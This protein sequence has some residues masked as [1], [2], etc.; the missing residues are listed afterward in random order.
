METGN[1]ELTILMP[2]LNE[3]NSLK[4]CIDKGKK[5]L[6]EN[7]I[8]GEVLVTDNGSTDGSQQIAVENGARVA[9]VAVKGYGSALMGGIRAARGKYVIMGDA[10]DS[11]NFSNLAP[12]VEKLRQGYDLVMGNRFRGGIEEGAMPFL[13]KY[14]GNPVLSKIGRIFFD[15]KIGDFH[16]G[17]RGFNRE[18]IS[19]LDLNTTGMEFASE[20]VIKSSL[21]QLKM[22]EVPTTLSRDKRDRPP[23]LRTWRDGWR[24]LRFMLLY[25]PNWLFL[26]PGMAM[27]VLGLLAAVLIFQ[28]P[29]TIGRITFDIHT[30]L[31]ASL[32]IMI[33]Y[34]SV[35][36][37]LLGKVFAVTEGFLPANSRFL[38]LFK[39]FNLEK[40]LLSGMILLL[41]GFGFLA[42]SVSLWEQTAFGDL[43]SAVVMRYLIPSV[44]LLSLGMQT[45]LTS[46]LFSLLGMKRK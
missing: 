15:I 8:N 16:C 23:H 6:A 19:A 35:T 26:Y 1:V 27:M 2:C 12:F 7:H 5:F 33:G 22:T 44:T 28:G 11:Y 43:N 29:Q 34:Q 39:T 31:V 17:L 32:V 24:H 30:L 46:F 14:L 45:V 10:D 20:M 13:H 25:S 37:S 3:A 42:Y 4:I 9:N 41:T 36:F 40:G 21:N 38:N 18:S